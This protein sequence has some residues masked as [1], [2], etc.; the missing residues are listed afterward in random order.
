MG[1]CTRRERIAGP[2]WMVKSTHRGPFHGQAATVVSCIQQQ[3]IKLT[4]NLSAIGSAGGMIAQELSLMI[5]ERVLTLTLAVTHA[6]DNRL[7][8]LLSLSNLL[9]NLPK[10]TFL[11]NKGGLNSFTPVSGWPSLVTWAGS[12]SKQVSFNLTN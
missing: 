2:P 1:V 3:D 4:Y 8:S 11:C 7:C 9:A 10:H 6:G 5:P 12:L